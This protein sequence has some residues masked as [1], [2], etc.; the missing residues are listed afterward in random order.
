MGL[1]FDWGEKIPIQYL[2]VP[3][4]QCSMQLM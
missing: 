4:P 1:N 3:Q 2:I